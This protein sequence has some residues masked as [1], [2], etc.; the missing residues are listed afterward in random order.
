MKARKGV[1]ES[2]LGGETMRSCHLEA[3]HHHLLLHPLAGTGVAGRVG[4]GWGGTEAAMR[5]Q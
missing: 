5:N 2:Y 3:F 1:T 4:I